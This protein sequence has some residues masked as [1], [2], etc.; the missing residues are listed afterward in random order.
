MFEALDVLMAIEKIS[1]RKIE[2]QQTH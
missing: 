1:T 2:F